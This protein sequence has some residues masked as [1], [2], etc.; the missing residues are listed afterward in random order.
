VIAVDDGS[1]DNT[2]SRLRTLA[3]ISPWLRLITYSPNRGRGHA[4]RAGIRHA[5]GNIICTID[6]D[7]SYTPDHIGKMLDAF[8]RYDGVDCVVGSPYTKGG[9]TENVPGWRLLLSRWGN[10]VISF[11]MGGTIKTSTGV[12]RAYRKE[13]IK[14]IELFA[15]GKELHLE[16]ISKILAAGF[17][18]V[19][20]PAILRSRKAGKSKFHFRA[21]AGSHLLFSLHEKPMI[22]FG[23][24]GLILVGLGLAGGGYL[25]Y[26]WQSGTLNPNRPLMTLLVIFLLT[27]LQ[28]LMFGFL[29]SG[30]VKLRKEI[31]VVQRQNKTLE[32]QLDQWEDRRDDS[33]ESDKSN[34]SIF[35][36]RIE[37][38][39]K[40][41]ELSGEATP[42]RN[43]SPAGFRQ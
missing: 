12:L 39:R 28:I 27:G 24:I 21:I 36:D 18:V 32:Q 11:A 16:I 34:E 37:K 40:Q 8:D 43:E 38:Q 29:G 17:T 20:M 26:L 10:K 5:T 31:F 33:V 7:L 19:E 14:S 25:I 9:S 15:D 41:V 23:V 42:D 22:L 4:I 2:E 1:T 6:A 3:A 35:D 13:C 30:L